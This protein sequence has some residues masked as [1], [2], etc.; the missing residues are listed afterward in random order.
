MNPSDPEI[1]VTF[2]MPAAL[3]DLI[4]DAANRKKTNTNRVFLDAMYL[5]LLGDSSNRKKKG[6]TNGAETLSV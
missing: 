4:K 2:N 5:Y 6:E 1:T 3:H